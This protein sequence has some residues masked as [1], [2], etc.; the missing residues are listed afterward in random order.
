[1]TA[2]HLQE[3]HRRRHLLVQPMLLSLM[4]LLLVHQHPMLLLRLVQ[5]VLLPLVHLLVLEGQALPWLLLLV[6]Q[7]LR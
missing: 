2:A 5:P 3:V 1:M 7:L 4:L 6:T